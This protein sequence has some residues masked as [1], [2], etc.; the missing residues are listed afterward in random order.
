M[1]R[2]FERRAL[3]TSFFCGDRDLLPLA[4][5][6]NDSNRPE[7]NQIDSGHEFG[8]ECGEK[9]PVPAQQMNQYGCDCNIERVI[10]GGRERPRRITET[11][12]F[13]EHRPPSPESWRL[14]SASAWMMG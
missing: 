8:S 10:G 1:L 9:F 4:I 13:A 7:G 3:L 2:A 14:E 5:N 6:I 12:K 11:Q